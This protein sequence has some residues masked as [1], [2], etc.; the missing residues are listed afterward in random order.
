[1]GHKMLPI[2]SVAQSSNR[3]VIKPNE[4]QFVNNETIC[5]KSLITYLVM[6][7]NMWT[8]DT[9][10]TGFNNTINLVKLQ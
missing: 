3:R 6:M 8:V 2:V 9:G 7:N 10:D 1:M 4:E 5:L